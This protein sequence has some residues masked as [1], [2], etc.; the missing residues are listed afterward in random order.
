MVFEKILAR[1]LIL[2]TRN[3]T[4]M[5]KQ[6]SFTKRNFRK[7]LLLGVLPIIFAGCQTMALYDFEGLKAPKV[8]I[9]PDVKTI[10]FVDR[11]LSFDLDTL[12]KYYEVN[13]LTL[14]DSVD[15]SEIRAINCH[16]GLNENLSAYFELD[17]VSYTRLP[18]NHVVGDRH[19]DPMSWDRVDSICE[20]NGSDIL[21]CLEDL[22]ISNEYEIIE[23]EENW[24]I[25]DV[26]YFAVWRIYDPLSQKFHDVRM[27]AD[28]LF[29][30]TSSYSYTKLIEEKMPKRAEINAEVAYDV[31]RDYADLISPSWI[32]FTR[33]YF[34]AGHQD[35]SFASYYL[36][37]DSV[38]QAIEMWK[39]HVDSDDKKLAGRACYNMALA[40]ELKEEYQEASSWVRR[41][42]K[43][44][45]EI[46]KEPK[47]FKYV[48]EY[49]K[50]LIGRTQNNY[51]L[52]KFFGKEK[53]E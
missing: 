16:L 6:I 23:G 42:I 15:Y 19:Y 53:T 48:K 32:S 17:S 29:T 1:K 20:S 8:I 21:I 13:N 50:E 36:N 33:K 37:N 30:E 10:G 39:K 24:G 22:Q 46:D 51:L 11:N 5:T 35:F 34:I 38:D 3:F 25:T 40:Y 26:K 31:G 27:I 44:Y 2:T 18:E 43:K 52:D 47:E 49:Y 12:S 14:K 28:S 9:P 4:Q 41:A 45:R 7:F